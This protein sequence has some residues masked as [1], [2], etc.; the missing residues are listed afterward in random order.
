MPRKALSYA[1]RMRWF[2]QARFGMF[3][4]WGLYSLLGRG[5]WVMFRERI[6]RDEYA[7][8]ARRFRGS[9]FD[10]AAWAALAARA[11][12]KYMVLTTRHH[13]GF[14]LFDSR[15]SDYSSA[16]TAAGR[17]FVA[18][19]VRACRQAGLKVGFYHSL[20]D[21]RFEGY[22]E[23]RRYN[24]SAEA[25]VT[26][27][28]GQ[29]RELMTR[30]GRIDYLFYDG[31]WVPGIPM[32]RQMTEGK[33]A[34]DVA[35]FWQSRKL[36]AMVRRL[37]PHIIIN[38]R[39]GVP[40]D[41]DTPEQHV[42]ASAAG[43]AWETCMTIGDS[44]GWGHVRNN[45][46]M[47]T[48][49]Q[50]LQHLVTAAAGEGNFLLNVGPRPDGS[51]R[52]EEAQRLRAMGKW[53]VRNG[54]AVYGSQRC[55]LNGGMIGTWTRKG[56]TGYLHLFRYPGREAAVPLVATK[57]RSAELLATG[58]RLKV[59]QEHNG[60]L[61]IS[62]LPSRPPHPYVNVVKVRF[63]GEPKLLEEKNRAAWLTGQAT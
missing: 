6:P 7:A 58:R 44:C 26:Q 63:A 21:W 53:L 51:I 17:D 38:N 37:Q 36:N 62:G 9:K 27:A 48:V 41:V 29:V 22:W 19:Y 56:S 40:E 15:L 1:Q 10:A 31:E 32:A 13:D 8:L 35:D 14:C 60:R 2:H 28:H 55:R 16:R 52:R 20:L 43:R 46:N 54:Q 59:R 5:E 3:I 4:H 23:H 11:G 18:D 49:P 61:V 39:S 33:T 57:A 34:A 42:T 30:Y 25:M 12:M 47:K 45:P 24:E 50:L